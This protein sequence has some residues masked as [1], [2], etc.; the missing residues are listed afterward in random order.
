MQFE[1]YVLNYDFNR[2]KIINYNIFNNIYVQEN[3]EKAIRKYLRAPKK[4]SYTSFGKDAKTLYGFDALCKKI[5]SI[6]MC[7]EWCRCE[8]EISVGNIFITEIKD[9]V[10][11][12]EQ[13]KLTTNNVYDELKQISQRNFDLEKFDC[14][15]QAKP[16][17][18]IIVR[19]VIY[20]YKE[21]KKNE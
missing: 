10:K 19:E 15:S 4:F 2:R 11:K 6:I 20:Q 16:N 13:E 8:Y 5:E 7:E 21:Q 18:P 12:I 17:I 3:T 1:F 14:F 9:V